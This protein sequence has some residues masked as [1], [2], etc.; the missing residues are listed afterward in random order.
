MPSIH[1]AFND[2]LRL[3]VVAI[4]DRWGKDLLGKLDEIDRSLVVRTERNFRSISNYLFPE[5]HDLLWRVYSIAYLTVLNQ[6]CMKNMYVIDE[7][8]AMADSDL[9]K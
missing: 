4:F 8:R 1:E 3:L 9:S 5:H 7:I 6:I 2:N